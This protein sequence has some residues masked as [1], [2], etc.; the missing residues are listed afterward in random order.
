MREDFTIGTVRQKSHALN[1]LLGLLLFWTGLGIGGNISDV[2]YWVDSTWTSLYLEWAFMLLYIVIARKL[3][4]IKGVW[5]HHRLAVDLVLIWAV[6]VLMAYLLSPYYSWQNPLAVM[7]LAETY[8]HMLFFFVLWECF[9]KFDINYSVL[10]GALIASTVT[11]MG[12][13]I[14][15]R[16][17]YPQLQADSHVFSIR[18]ESL[19]LNTHVHRIGYQ[20]E[21]AL[22]LLTAF[23]IVKKARVS[24]AILTIALLIF[25]IWLGGRAA[26]LGTA[27]AGSVF[28]YSIRREVSVKVY[29]LAGA[30]AVLFALVIMA[31][32]LPGTEYIVN[33]LRKTFYAGSLSE[34]TA[35][36]TEVWALALEK[37]GESWWFGTGPQ[38]YFFYPHRPMEVIHAHNAFLQFLGEWGGIGSLLFLIMLFFGVRSGMKLHA[39]LPPSVKAYH[40]AAGL[41]LVA[42]GVTS[43]FGGVFFFHQTT[44][45]F[46][47][48]FALWVAPKG[49]T[50]T[51]P[52]D[53]TR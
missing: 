43:L 8:T 45:Y 5:R 16:Y 23:L 44:L 12:Y 35:G 1:V 9:R 11:V 3:P 30:V 22:M 42:L 53:I 37:I 41:A 19:L 50:R 10:F 28:L 52:Y 34:M 13:F 36:R 49:T 40:K 21:T 48:A 46:I 17:A 15:I 32:N 47:F 24:A 20:V 6:W 39:T 14:Y 26:V 38:S 4:D 18:S 29:L 51:H 33:A 7:R 31:A 25:L 27:V 2:R